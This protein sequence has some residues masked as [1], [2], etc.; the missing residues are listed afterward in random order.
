[1]S[2]LASIHGGLSAP[3][4]CSEHLDNLHHAYGRNNDGED[5]VHNRQSFVNTA[6]FG[7][8]HRPTAFDTHSS[9]P[10]GRL[11]FRLITLRA[12]DAAQEF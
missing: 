6:R 4:P 2:F 9:E 1:L 10:Y 3:S 8:L 12:S 5:D 7:R 11:F